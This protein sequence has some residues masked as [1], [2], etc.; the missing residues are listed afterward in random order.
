MASVVPLKRSV[1]APLLPLLLLLSLP[2]LASAYTANV[3]NPV[4]S[5]YYTRASCTCDGKYTTERCDDIWATKYRVRPPSS[6]VLFPADSTVA[7]VIES[8]GETT[9]DY[10]SSLSDLPLQ[11]RRILQRQLQGHLYHSSPPHPHCPRSPP[12]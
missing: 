6:L 4:L 3:A 7:A 12:C 11:R 5:G 2:L 10:F 9:F 8:E 1:L